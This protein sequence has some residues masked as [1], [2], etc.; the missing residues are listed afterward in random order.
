MFQPTRQRERPATAPVRKKASDLDVRP[1]PL[2]IFL[3]VAFSYALPKAYFKSRKFARLATRH[4]CFRQAKARD[5]LLLSRVLMHDVPQLPS[6]IVSLQN[7]TGEIKVREERLHN[8]SSKM[9]SEESPDKRTLRARSNSLDKFFDSL[10][11]DTTRH[12]F[13]WNVHWLSTDNLHFRRNSDASIEPTI[14]RSFGLR[15]W[16][17]RTFNGG[18]PARPFCLFVYFR[19]WLGSANQVAKRRLL[20][21]QIFNLYQIA[22]S[23]SVVDKRIRVMMWLSKCK[24]SP[25]FST[26]V[27]GWESPSLLLSNLHSS[28]PLLRRPKDNSDFSLYTH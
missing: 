25:Q 28:S 9:F 2:T 24:P 13:V 26:P 3:I 1:N 19:R 20:N 12:P 8:I 5:R 22:C 27:K 10:G 18:Q 21:S 16:S 17:F 7:T 11:K 14:D 6:L 4:G 15:L 23:V